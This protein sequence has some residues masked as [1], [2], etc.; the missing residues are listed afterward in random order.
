MPMLFQKTELFFH[1]APMYPTPLL[2]SLY[3]PRWGELRWKSLEILELRVNY[4]YMC[5]H[6]HTCFSRV[7]GFFILK[8]FKI[9]KLANIVLRHIL[10]PISQLPSVVVA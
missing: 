10:H 7:G 1:S 9:K 8:V 5:V 2:M 4:M 6:I 3:L